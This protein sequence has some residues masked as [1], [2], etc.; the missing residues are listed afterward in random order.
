MVYEF[1][2]GQ[3]GSRKRLGS[4]CHAVERGDGALDEV[5]EVS[6]RIVKGS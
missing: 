2:E 6:W 4:H 1:E 3:N 5:V